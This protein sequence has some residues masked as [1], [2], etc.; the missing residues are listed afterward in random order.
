VTQDAVPT[1]L[2]R[3]PASDYVAR[4]VGLNLYAG[5]LENEVIHVDGGGDVVAATAMRRGRVTATVRPSAVT[6]YLQPL[7]ST[8]ARNRWHGRI[9]SVDPMGERCRV[10]VDSMPPVIAEVTAA[11]LAELQIGVGDDVWASFKATDVEVGT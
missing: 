2:L 4:L 8:S 7:P 10:V 1:E 6:L 5:E 9:T 11:A 3:H